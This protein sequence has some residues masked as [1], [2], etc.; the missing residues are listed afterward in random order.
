MREE[1]KNHL[2]MLFLDRCYVKKKM[3]LSFVHRF[4]IPLNPKMKKA[5]IEKLMLM[6]Y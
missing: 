3:I 6:R 4:K 5:L 2:F 1:K